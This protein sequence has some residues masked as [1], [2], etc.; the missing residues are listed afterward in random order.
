MFPKGTRSGIK[1][2]E[3]YKEAMRHLLCP[4]PDLSGQGKEQTYLKWAT[5]QLCGRAQERSMSGAPVILGDL[6]EPHLRAHM[7]IGHSSLSLWS[8]ADPN[9]SAKP[10]WG[11]WARLLIDATP[12][13]PPQ[14]RKRR[15]EKW[16]AN[17]N[18]VHLLFTFWNHLT[19]LGIPIFKLLKS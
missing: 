3:G 8:S 4:S 5:E 14:R 9:P 10:T 11:L 18:P 17:R 19:I 1:V 13:G 15:K 6:P 12:T 7:H 2:W 16:E